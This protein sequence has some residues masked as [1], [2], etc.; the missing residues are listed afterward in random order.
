MN[1]GRA[2]YLLEDD[3]ENEE[4][5]LPMNPKINKVMNWMAIIDVCFT[6]SRKQRECE[7]E[8]KMNN[9]RVIKSLMKTGRTK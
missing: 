9:T 2:E 3:G 8:V 5:C 7:G 6:K 1:S 4:I